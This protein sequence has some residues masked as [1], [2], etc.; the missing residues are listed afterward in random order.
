[1]KGNF[2]GSP[3]SCR[4]GQR[5]REWRTA[6]GRAYYASFHVARRLLADLGFL[7]PRADRAHSYLSLR[8]QNSGD[9]GE[10]KAGA[11]FNSLRQ[12]RNQ[13]DYDL[14]VPMSRA[15][16]AIQVRTAQQIIQELDAARL[17][18]TRTQITDAM[19]V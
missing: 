17:E 1:M 2:S 3:P 15:L 10:D 19:R 9:P 8:L 14:L 12:R 4:P 16:A 13:A 7:V 6:V 5:R 18:P 11:D